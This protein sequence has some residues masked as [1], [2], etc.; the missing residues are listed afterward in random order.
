MSDISQ[1]NI[2]RILFRLYKDEIAVQFSGVR[3]YAAYRRRT[4]FKYAE[5]ELRWVTIQTSKLNDDWNIATG[6]VSLRDTSLPDFITNIEDESVV[7]WLKSILSL[8]GRDGLVYDGKLIADHFIGTLTAQDYSVSWAMEY[9]AFI[10]RNFN[11]QSLSARNTV[12]SFRDGHYPLLTSRM[13][14]WCVRN[15]DSRLTDST[16][17]SLV[18]IPASSEKKFMMRCKTFSEYLA[19]DL[20]ISNALK[21]I[22][23]VE[24]RKPLKGTMGGNKLFG[25]SF[26]DEYIRGKEVL[27][28]DDVYHHGESFRQISGVLLEMGAKIIT[29][30]CIAKTYRHDEYRLSKLPSGLTDLKETAP[31]W[32]GKPDTPSDDGWH[33]IVL[34]R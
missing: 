24:D 16:D 21:A 34:D 2:A 30:I 23:V 29:G 6:F 7:Y 12:F 19:A 8:L 31:Q 14:A 32:T 9:H 27:L 15:M 13:M 33:W 25:L 26:H 4:F 17:V 3:F 5:Q 11:E 18:C 10:D 22:R 20:R 28:F 1:N